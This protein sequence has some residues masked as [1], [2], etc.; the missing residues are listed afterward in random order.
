MTT[1]ASGT[2]AFNGTDLT[3]QPTT[4]KY[5]ERS[6]YGFAGNARPIYSAFRQF[7]LTWEL[8]STSD[9]KQLIDFYNTVSVTGTLVACLP[10][11]G[12][13]NFVFINITGVTLT[14]PTVEE[15]FQG[16]IKTV[17]MLVINIPFNAS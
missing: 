13:T 11:W 2:Y 3:L 6:Q 16:F 14:E 1:G 12:D 4:G 8:E 15:Y 5:L 10:R 9:A 17:K 7:E